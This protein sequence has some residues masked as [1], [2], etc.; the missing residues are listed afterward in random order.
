MAVGP[1]VGCHLAEARAEVAGALATANA[2]VRKLR[3]EQVAAAAAAAAYPGGGASPLGSLSSSAAA[4]SPAPYAASSVSRLDPTVGQDPS[5][6]PA[7]LSGAVAE[8]GALVSEVIA[9]AQMSR[10]HARSTVLAPR[11]SGSGAAGGYDGGGGHSGRGGKHSDTSEV[12]ELRRELASARSQMAQLATEQQQQ[13]QRQQRAHGAAGGA[14]A[15]GP[16]P[17]VARL[18]E[19]LAGCFKVCTRRATALLTA[20]YMH[21]SR[22]CRTV[23]ALVSHH[24]GRCRVR[25]GHRLRVGCAGHRLRAVCAG[26]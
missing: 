8:L 2:L 5:G 1:Y 12:L 13:Q 25:A 17:A 7:A 4:L 9:A 22:L 10:L 14:L 18:T 21:C 15:G 26:H 24:R 11:G 23:P 3:A 6:L 20:K 16:P 19:L